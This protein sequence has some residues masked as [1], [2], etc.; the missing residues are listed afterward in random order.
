LPQAVQWLQPGLGHLA[1][2]EDPVGT[3]Q[4]ILRWCGA[5]QV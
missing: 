5:G 2:E 3:A 1:H 4:Q